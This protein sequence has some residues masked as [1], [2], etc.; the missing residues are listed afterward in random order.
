M[1]ITTFSCLG[2]VVFAI[3]AIVQMV[4][5]RDNDGIGHSLIKAG[6]ALMLS[7]VPGTLDVFVSFTLS[8]V[9]NDSENIGV[10]DKGY[11]YVLMVAGFMLILI[12]IV[13][14]SKL[15]KRIYILNLFGINKKEISERNTLKQL[16]LQDY[17]VKE[18]IINIIP[19]FEDGLSIDEN[20]NK[21]ITV[22]IQDGAIS[23]HTR[24]GEDCGCFTGMAPIPYT[25]FAGTFLGS[26]NLNRFFE[27]NR[28]SED[29][30]YELR[31]SKK[32]F[33]KKWPKLHEIETSA[34]G[35]TNI[36]EVALAI[37]VT[38]EISTEDLVQFNDMPVVRLGLEDPQ[39]NIIRNK[40]QL[41][42]YKKVIHDYLDKILRQRY[43]KIK[44]VHLVAS[45]PSCLSI[46][47]G[48]LIG[49]G[50][51]RMPDIIAYHYIVSKEPRYLFGIYVSGNQ[52]G[53][54]ICADGR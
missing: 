48:R 5:E 13:V 17:R 19:I 52:K 4:T 40:E 18:Q 54:L 32:L 20:L 37:S 16:K 43:P 36:S 31:K 47:I 30:Y 8:M 45:I 3:L 44:K 49:M 26:A 42:E 53:S 29:G 28:N 24:I 50:K 2:V 33:E 25:I 21:F 41:L 10:I 9:S 39:D 23:F 11:T 34:Q 6:V 46:E 51:N 22:L 35:D 15:R 12:G 14:V 38:H 7:G 1:P 27:Y